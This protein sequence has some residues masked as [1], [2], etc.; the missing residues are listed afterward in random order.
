MEKRTN[1]GWVLSGMALVVAAML[2]APLMA[3]ESQN[4]SGVNRSGATGITLRALQ[5]GVGAGS[6]SATTMGLRSVV[7]ACI[8]PPL[9]CSQC[10]YLD[11]YNAINTYVGGSSGTEVV[12]T[13]T[14][15]GVLTAGQPYLI[16]VSGTSS[17]WAVPVWTGTTIGSPEPAPMF[18]SPAVL[19]ASQGDVGFDWEYIFA[20]P[21]TSHGDFLSGGP[22]EVYYQGISLDNG[23]T[24]QQLTPI[25]GQVYNPQHV[26]QFVVIGQGQNAQARTSDFG[27]HNDNYGRYKICFQR[28]I[29]CT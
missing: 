12:N 7:T 24:F 5:E 9:S 21:N 28:L 6:M 15:S 14:T 11:T 29:P 2:A 16:T 13:I 22:V 4:Q 26:Y 23:A 25:A 27:P 19:T 18:L 17:Y 10:L 20:Y 1:K 3:Q 8:T